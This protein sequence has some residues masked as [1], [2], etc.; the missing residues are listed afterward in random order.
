MTPN[1]ESI[2]AKFLKKCDYADFT[3]KSNDF[4]E[5]FVWRFPIVIHTCDCPN[6]FYQ[7]SFSFKV[8]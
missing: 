2:N 4:A 1:D 5:I 6:C 3:K 7:I 8:H